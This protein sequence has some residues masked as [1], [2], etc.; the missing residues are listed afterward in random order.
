MTEP[1][2]LTWL[3]FYKLHPFDDM[4]R[5]FRPAA[6]I[7]QSMSGGDMQLKLDY[8]EPPAAG[9]FS[10]ADINTFRAFGVV[11]PRRI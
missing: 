10:Q 3:E 9:N 1:E 8:L 2:F 4:H 5:F 7:A 6:L 11:P